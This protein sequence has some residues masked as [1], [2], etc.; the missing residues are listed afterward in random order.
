MVKKVHS[1]ILLNALLVPLCIKLPQMNGY[2]KYFN[3]RKGMNLLVHDKELL[4]KYNEIWD[5][6][7][8][9]LKKGLVITG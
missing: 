9:L 2:V 8:N 5:K 6:I 3:Y 1:N 4:K 7:R